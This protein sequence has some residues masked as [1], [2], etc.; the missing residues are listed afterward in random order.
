MTIPIKPP[1]ETLKHINQSY[2]YDCISGVITN[3]KNLPVGSISKNRL[4]LKIKGKDYPITNICWFLYY[5]QW[6]DQEIDH[7]DRDA[8]NNSIENLRKATFSQ[9]T[10][11]KDRRIDN[12]Y[13]GV[14]FHPI[15]NKWR[16]RFIV[17]YKKYEV[18]GFKT[19]K[20]AARAREQHLDQLGDT[21]CARN[22]D[23]G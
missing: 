17:S 7:K 1:D 2:I 19:A 3:K 9:N 18:Y 21:F 12:K 4:R 14:S 15:G 11:N 10:S 22:K 23:L 6:P 20:E 5:G 8:L 13:H 16:Y